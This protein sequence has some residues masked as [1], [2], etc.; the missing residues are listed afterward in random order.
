LVADEHPEVRW[1]LRT[2]LREELGLTVVGEAVEANGLIRVAAAARPDL[3]VLEWELPGGP[4]PRLL[5]VL[6][7]LDPRAKT[8]V[9]GQYPDCRLPALAAGAD[10][11]VCKTTFPEQLRLALLAVAGE[12]AA[13][14]VGYLRDNASGEELQA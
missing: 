12:Q 14:G 13:P 2:F 1:A 4:G 9:V 6:H 8:L 7:R 11:F 5:K 10:G 3:V